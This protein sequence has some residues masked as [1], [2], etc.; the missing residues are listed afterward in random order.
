[1]IMFTFGM[2]MHFY[3]NKFSLLDLVK[4]TEIIQPKTAY[5]LLKSIHLAMPIIQYLHCNGAF[6]SGYPTS[7]KYTTNIE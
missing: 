5:E 6:V 4:L 3:I 7:L 2:L 1:M